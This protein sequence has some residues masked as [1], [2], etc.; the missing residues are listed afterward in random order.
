MLAWLYN[1][2]NAILPIVIIYHAVINAA[3]RFVLPGFAN[4]N[5]QVVWSFMVGLYVLAAA[6]VTL[7]NAR[8]SDDLLLPTP[9]REG[10]SDRAD[11]P[12][13]EPRSVQR[14]RAC[15]GVQRREKDKG[16][17]ARAMPMR[18]GCSQNFADSLP[19]QLNCLMSLPAV[20]SR[21][22]ARR[23]GD[24]CGGPCPRI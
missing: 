2:T 20:A 13:T 14:L 24:W 1:S 15:G 4:K 12:R 6:I 8:N 18:S 5:Y 9:V 22:F 21:R 17:A 23:D 19:R 7:S 11:D 16:D 10:S 3:D